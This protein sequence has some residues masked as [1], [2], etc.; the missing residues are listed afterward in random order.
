MKRSSRGFTLIELVIVVAIIGVLARI[1]YPSY[2]KYIISVSRQAAQSQLVELAN[3][4][5]KIF[6]NSSAYTCNV[7]NAYTGQSSGGLGITSGTTSDGNYNIQ[8]ASGCSA[9]SF[10]LQAAPISGKPPASDGTISIDQTGT[11]L[12]NGNPW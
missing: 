1:A 6:L 11:R 2:Q 12:W 4:Q 9:T 7:S 10:T 3:S 8:F 5:E